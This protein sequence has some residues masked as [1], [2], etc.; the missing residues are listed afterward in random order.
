MTLTKTIFV[1]NVAGFS[2][3]GVFARGPTA[4]NQSRFKGNHCT[5]LLDG[6]FGGGLFAEDS[7]TIDKSTFIGN[8]AADGGGILH[9]GNEAYIA[10][11]L[12][13]NNVADTGIIVISSSDTITILHTTIVD[14]T[15]NGHKAILIEGGF[16]EIINTLIVNFAI[17]LEKLENTTFEDYNLFFNTPITKSGTI[18]SGGH[19]LNGDPKFIDA[20][21]NDYRLGAGSAAL[22]RGINVG[23]ITDLEENL[24]PQG[25]GFDI[26]AY[27]GQ[28][29]IPNNLLYLPLIF[30]SNL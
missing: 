26:G 21:N 23:L 17:G 7:L 25:T 5:K 1:D 4:I 18:A 22:D 9:Q 2:G 10:N 13:A 19:S 29:D 15:P 6:C 12:F 24:R 16:V 14:T 3:G 30:K 8:S 28:I 20:V 11:S 27:E